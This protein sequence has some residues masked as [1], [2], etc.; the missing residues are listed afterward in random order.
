MTVGCAAGSQ[1]TCERFFLLPGRHPDSGKTREQKS[2]RQ[3]LAENPFSHAEEPMIHW[4][5]FTHRVVLLTRF[6]ATDRFSAMPA[7][8][9]ATPGRLQTQK[10]GEAT[11]APNGTRPSAPT[12]EEPAAVAAGT[13]CSSSMWAGEY[14]TPGSGVLSQPQRHRDRRRGS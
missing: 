12:I 10:N 4:I 14:S 5:D 9:T 7:P 13:V 2:G 8:A 3:T 1:T 11:A 6:S